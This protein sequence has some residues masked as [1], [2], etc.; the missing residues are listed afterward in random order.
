ME[1]M[2]HQHESKHE[3]LKKEYL[4]LIKSESHEGVL[5]GLQTTIANKFDAQQVL[6]SLIMVSELQ[7]MYNYVTHLIMIR[8]HI[9]KV[10][11][12]YFSFS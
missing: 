2:F 5:S 7:T 11:I 1:M 9:R 10:K 12:G 3:R 8:K 4:A 6:S